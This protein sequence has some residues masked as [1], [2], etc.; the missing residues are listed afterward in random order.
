MHKSVGK[1]LY[2]SRKPFKHSDLENIVY[3]KCPKAVKG[4]PFKMPSAYMKFLVPANSNPMKSRDYFHS[5]V[6]TQRLEY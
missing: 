1:Y 3:R 2:Y 4:D 6:A 5:G